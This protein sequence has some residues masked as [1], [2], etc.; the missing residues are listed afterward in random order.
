MRGRV[1]PYILPKTKTEEEVLAHWGHFLTYPDD[2][3]KS[4]FMHMQG[5]WGLLH[6]EGNQALELLTLLRMKRL[7]GPNNYRPNKNTRKPVASG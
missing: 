2:P 5:A 4:M 6:T 3:P 7:N 1:L